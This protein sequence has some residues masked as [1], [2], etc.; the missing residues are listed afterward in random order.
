MAVKYY[1]FNNKDLEKIL[2]IKRP[3]IMLDIVKDIIPGKSAHGF[4]HIK[5]SDWSFESHY[6]YSSVPASVQIEAMLQTLITILYTLKDHHGKLAY[7]TDI[8]TKLLSKVSPECEFHIFSEI[9][10]FKRGLSHGISKGIVNDNIVCK[11]E[12]HFVSPH[13]FPN[14]LK[15]TKNS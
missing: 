11:G 3:F 14:V 4:K 8:K 7:I 2:L 10:S 6:E 5:K 15:G 13:L 1:S 9:L 12:F